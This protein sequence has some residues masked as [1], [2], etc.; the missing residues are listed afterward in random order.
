M[1]LLKEI[2]G[3]DIDWNEIDD[4]HLVGGVL[5]QFILRLPEPLIPFSIYDKLLNIAMSGINKSKCHNKNR[6]KTNI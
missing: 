1:N 4:K 2:I 3:E 5:M 6:I